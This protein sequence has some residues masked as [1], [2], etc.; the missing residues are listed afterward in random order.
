[1]RLLV[2]YSKIPSFEKNSF[3]VNSFRIIIEERIN[4]EN[5]R[6]NLLI[7]II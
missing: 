2:L 3:N 4:I 1:M 6:L 7:F 5:K